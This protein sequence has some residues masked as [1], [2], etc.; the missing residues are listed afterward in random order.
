MRFRVISL[1]KNQINQ[2]VIFEGK[3]TENGKKFG[4]ITTI[5]LQ[6]WCIGSS[7]FRD[8]LNISDG[9]LKLALKML[10]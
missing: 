2:G 10:V 1:L 6:G 8:A 5:F 3:V 4:N 9:L 7:V